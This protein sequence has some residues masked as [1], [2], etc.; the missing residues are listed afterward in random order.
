[1]LGAQRR[2]FE[3]GVGG[4]TAQASAAGAEF[5]LGWLFLPHPPA[6]LA[7]ADPDP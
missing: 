6:G 2:I 5:V 3:F 1:M 4:C 7:G